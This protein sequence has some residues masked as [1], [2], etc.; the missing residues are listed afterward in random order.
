MY[1]A[2]SISEHGE[3]GEKKTLKVERLAKKNGK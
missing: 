1:P 3:E 2:P